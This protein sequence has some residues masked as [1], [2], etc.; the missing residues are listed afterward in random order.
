MSRFSFLAIPEYKK[1][2]IGGFFRYSSRIKQLLLVQ[3]LRLL[4]L[5]LP[6]S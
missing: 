6:F 1:P 2:A 3:Q 5:Q 4:E